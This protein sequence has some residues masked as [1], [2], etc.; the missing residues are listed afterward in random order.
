MYIEDAKMNTIYQ[1]ITKFPERIKEAY[2]TEVPKIIKKKFKRIL[3]FGMG[4]CYIAGLSIKEFLREDLRIPVEVCNGFL[5]LSSL[6]KNTLIILLSY[7]GETKEVL[8]FFDKI[9][10]KYSK[11]ILILTS[12]GELGEKARKSKVSLIEVTPNLHQ[13]FTFNYIFFPL[14]KFFEDSK[15]IKSKNEVVEK[16]IKTVEKNKK[17]LDKEAEKLSK[18]FKSKLRARYPLIYAT[19]YFYPIAYRFQTSLEEDDKILSH[20]NKITELFHNELEVL[21][22]KKFFPILIIDENETSKFKPQ[23]DFFKEHLKKYYEFANFNY[24]REERMFLAFYFIDFLGYH[25]SK[26]KK[27]RMGET[28]LS[29]KIKKM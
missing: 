6:R 1:L 27:T 10:D 22:D 12:G 13:R 26:L 2:K 17:K 21:P 18:K 9:K 19:E 24:S 23:L 8:D 11:N 5:E 28:P 16:I 25:I 7:S 29:D 14:L 4:G 3:I 20:S 15:F